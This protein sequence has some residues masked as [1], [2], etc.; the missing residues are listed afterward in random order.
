M[1]LERETHATNEM[2]RERSIRALV[3]DSIIS[4]VAVHVRVGRESTGASLAIL[5]IRITP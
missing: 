5:K 2:R 1:N 3:K 4:L